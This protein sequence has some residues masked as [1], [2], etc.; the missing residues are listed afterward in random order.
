M[1]EHGVLDDRV[2]GEGFP[3]GESGNSKHGR[4]SV[5]DF[6]ISET[7]ASVGVISNRGVKVQRIEVVV[8]WNS[9]LSVFAV[10]HI[11]TVH[12]TEFGVVVSSKSGLVFEES[13]GGEEGN[14]GK[15]GR[16]VESVE[17]TRSA[18]VLKHPRR[19]EQFGHGP[20]NNSEHG[21]ASVTKFGFLHGE[22]IELLGESKRIETVVS[23]LGSLK[24]RRSLQEWDS[25]R[26]FFRS[27]SATVDEKRKN[28]FRE[29]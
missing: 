26:I 19:S 18:S 9:V 23:G 4:S 11:G 17:D 10:G 22:Q 29:N 28:E 6:D 5:A 12:N 13:G 21:K 20:S 24:L 16:N 25:G 14:N 7:L 27:S 2:S 3:G 8:T 15:E 1:E